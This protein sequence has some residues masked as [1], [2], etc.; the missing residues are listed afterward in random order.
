[1]TP[2]EIKELVEKYYGIEDIGINNRRADY[3]AARVVYFML[4]RRNTSASYQ[5]MAELVNRDHSTVVH[6]LKTYNEVWMGSPILFK[7][8]LMDF[9]ILE[10]QLE[11]NFSSIQDRPELFDIFKRQEAHID[12]LIGRIKVLETEN[13]R[14]T[15]MEKMIAPKLYSLGIDISNYK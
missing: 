14:L 4:C 8:Q 9:H 5:K 3:V 13:T 10:E 11:I 1:M 12:K 6:A 15:R 2:E 7:R